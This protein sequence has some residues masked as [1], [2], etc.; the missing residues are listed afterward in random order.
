MIIHYSYKNV[1]Y[2]YRPMP[3]PEA[4]LLMEQ[5]I[6]GKFRSV[7]ALGS[8][9]EPKMV[10]LQKALDLW[11]GRDDVVYIGVGM[12]YET[13]PEPKPGFIF[14]SDFLNT[15]LAVDTDLSARELVGVCKAIEKS[16][17]RDF[18][19]EHDVKNGDRVIDCDLIFHGDESVNED[20]LIVPHTRWDMRNFVVLPLCDIRE[21]L[22]I[23]QREKVELAVKNVEIIPPYGKLR[24]PVK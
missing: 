17:G 16:C 5:E 8:N 22:T 24:S 14:D 6:S 21:Y 9:L 4:L 10:A 1:V 11:R 13:E 15:C 3:K 19:S 7:I 18:E 2:D 23:K 12:V 20:G